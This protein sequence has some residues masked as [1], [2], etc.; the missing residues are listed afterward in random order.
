MSN[1]TYGFVFDANGNI[2]AY[3]KDVIGTR[4]AI[5][6]LPADFE[7]FAHAKWKWNGTALVE[8]ADF[9]EP[10]SSRDETDAEKEAR[11]N[12]LRELGVI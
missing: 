2:V 12:K 1:D 9:A 4:I 8:R 11:L 7:Q 6:D 10:Q 5:A 3:G